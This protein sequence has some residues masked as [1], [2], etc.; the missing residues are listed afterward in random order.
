MS[1]S[2]VVNLVAHDDPSSIGVAKAWL[3]AADGCPVA[4]MVLEG[5]LLSRE[6]AG[7]GASLVPVRSARVG[8]AVGWGAALQGVLTDRVTLISGPAEVLPGW[9]QPGVFELAGVADERVYGGGFTM[10]D[11]ASVRGFDT[12]LGD[13]EELLADLLGRVAALEPTT[14][15][16]AGATA[17]LRNL[18]LWPAR[19]V[20]AP[21]I[22]SVLIVG[23]GPDRRQDETILAAQ[24]QSI[25]DIDV[26]V[27]NLTG[28]TFPS[29][30]VAAHS[31]VPRLRF[32]AWGGVRR[33]DISDDPVT[34][35]RRVVDALEGQWTLLLGSDDIVLPWA[36]ES[37]LKQLAPHTRSIAGL[38]VPF[39]RDGSVPPRSDRNLETVACVATNLLRRW[40]PTPVASVAELADAV[41]GRRPQPSPIAVALTPGADDPITGAPWRTTWARGVES[42]RACLPDRFGP[43]TL[44]LRRN[45][46]LKVN[47]LDAYDRLD[48]L[49]AEFDGKGRLFHESA[50]LTPCTWRD[51]AL[52]SRGGHAFEAFLGPGAGKDELDRAIARRRRASP[53]AEAAIVEGAPAVPP[54]NPPAGG[55]LFHR[56][57]GPQVST[58]S[59]EQEAAGR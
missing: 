50:T 45:C 18:P 39:D 41:V 55:W 14:V 32:G 9:Q 29:E 34:G 57:P 17:P 3:A 36:A 43:R 4:V 51:M 23:S 59:F 27:V 2:L 15:G 1:A 53:G 6:L 37:M 25:D 58:M 49:V 52:L 13:A 20:A 56:G 16:G 33:H 35:W 31:V 47:E 44:V 42:V 11:Y 26:H 24:A 8:R 5:G 46:V 21:P 7:E 38:R 30:W 19:P 40:W 22:L 48:E 10:A 28:D 54:S 12:R